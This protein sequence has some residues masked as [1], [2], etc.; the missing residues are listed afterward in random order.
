MHQLIKQGA[1]Q[2]CLSI[3]VIQPCYLI[4]GEPKQTNFGHTAALFD[5]FYLNQTP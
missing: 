5:N 1:T 3:Q 2:G 4:S